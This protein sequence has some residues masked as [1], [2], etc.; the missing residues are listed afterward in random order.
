MNGNQLRSAYGQVV[1][2]VE[3]LSNHVKGG[4]NP[5]TAKVDHLLPFRELYFTYVFSRSRRG[6]NM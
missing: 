5:V 2:S 6:C 3:F 1:Y 4:S